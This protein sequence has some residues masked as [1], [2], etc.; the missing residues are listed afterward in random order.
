MSVLNADQRGDGLVDV[1]A[2]ELLLQLPQVEGAVGEV[3]QRGDEAAGH[4]RRATYQITINNSKT[5]SFRTS[6]HLALVFIYLSLKI[7][8]FGVRPS[9]CWHSSLTHTETH[10]TF[11][12]TLQTQFH[13]TKRGKERERLT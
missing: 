3:L 13:E 2:P 6:F 11:T 9:V 5:K 1:G 7:T 4:V 10:N 8:A 12:H